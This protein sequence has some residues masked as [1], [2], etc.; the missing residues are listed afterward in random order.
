MFFQFLYI[1]VEYVHYNVKYPWW[2][3]YKIAVFNKDDIM[4]IGLILKIRPDLYHR[5]TD[6]K[7]HKRKFSNKFQLMGQISKTYQ[8]H[9]EKYVHIQNN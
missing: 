4:Y 5:I 6:D 7:K 1:D 3:I 9:V 8:N 2:S